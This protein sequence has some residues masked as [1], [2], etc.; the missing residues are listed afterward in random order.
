MY[1]T[2]NCCCSKVRT[3]HNYK[4]LGLPKGCYYNNLSYAIKAKSYS[5]RRSMYNGN[6]DPIIVTEIKKKGEVGQ[7]NKFDGY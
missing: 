1:L 7:L 5:T 6:G 2:W 3:C 4:N